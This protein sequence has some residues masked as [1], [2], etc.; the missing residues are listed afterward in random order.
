MSAARTAAR[1]RD[2]YGP[3]TVVTGASSG[4]GQACAAHLAAAGLDVVLVAR[5]ADLLTGLAERLHAEH[6]GQTRVLPVDLA[7]PTGARRVAEQT[8]D[9]DVGLLVQAAGFGTAGRFL[10]ADLAEQL[11]ML[12]VNCQAVLDLAH[13]FAPRLAARPTGGGMVLFGSL[14][15]RQGAPGAAHYGATKAW[16]QALGEALHVEL[17]PRGVDVL[18]ATPG[19]VRSGFAD[20]AG[21]RLDTAVSAERVAAGA[22]E[23][24]VRGRMTASPGALSKLLGGSLGPLP[25]PLRTRVMSRVVRSLTA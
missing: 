7:A 22:L 25:R 5:R 18:T 9:L 8:A 12:A 24:L 6:G 15:G 23:G 10:D 1:L 20:R 11:E 21:M 2:R 14:V 16:V 3:W 19:P 17:A 4:I 13:R